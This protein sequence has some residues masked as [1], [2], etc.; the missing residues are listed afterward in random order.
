MRG[1]RGEGAGVEA[2][3]VEARK[4]GGGRREERGGDGGRG[5]EWSQG[6]E[7]FPPSPFRLLAL[8]VRFPG[9]RW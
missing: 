7:S 3:L 6:M 1:E 5:W 8:S 9:P 2:R 4:E